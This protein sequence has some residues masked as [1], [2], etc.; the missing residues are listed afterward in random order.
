MEHKLKSFIYG[1]ILL[2]FFLLLSPANAQS[3]INRV[4][5]HPGNIITEVGSNPIH[6]S[7]LAFDS[8]NQPIW[9]GITYE[10]GISSSNSIATLE[11]NNNLATFFP[12]NPGTGDLYVVARYQGDYL[13]GSISVN[14]SS[15]NSTP[16]P[17]PVPGD[18]NGDQKVDGLDYVIW[19]SHYNQ[20]TGNGGYAVVVSL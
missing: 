17:P 5:I 1:F 12:L 16:T 19:L 10:W 9:S 15:P 11:T 4:D 6:L 7:T 8:N 3:A 18:A 14:V 2:T 20:S 13:S